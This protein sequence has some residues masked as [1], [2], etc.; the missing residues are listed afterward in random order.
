LEVNDTAQ[1]AADLGRFNER[2]ESALTLHDLSDV[3]FF[4]F[5]A[6]KG[7]IFTIDSQFAEADFQYQVTV[8]DSQGVVLGQGNSESVSVVLDTAQRASVKVAAVDGSVGAYDLVFERTGDTKGGNKG[9]GKGGRLKLDGHTGHELL[10]AQSEQPYHL[11]AGTEVTQSS[12]TGVFRPASQVPPTVADRCVAVLQEPL[13]PD[14]L[15]AVA[16]PRFYTGREGIDYRMSF[17]EWTSDDLD[18]SLRDHFD[19]LDDLPLEACS[20]TS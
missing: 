19:Q 20:F 15:S 10:F 18:M 3:D 16:E 17:R 14:V 2:T 11:V 7:G 8:Y 4:K 1:S 6:K 12:V 9:R 5:T 13:G